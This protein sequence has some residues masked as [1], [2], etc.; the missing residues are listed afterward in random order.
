M[1][2]L[3]SVGEDTKRERAVDEEDQTGGKARSEVILTITW[4]E[5]EVVGVLLGQP[6]RRQQP[7]RR[8]R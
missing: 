4:R 1:D 5:V 7:K 3:R 6:Q 2:Y 8:P